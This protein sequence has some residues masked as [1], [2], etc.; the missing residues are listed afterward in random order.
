[1]SLHPT[2][3][4]TVVS[5]RDAKRRGLKRT[6]RCS[7][8]DGSLKLSVVT[9]SVIPVSSSWSGSR[10]RRQ[11]PSRL[12]WLDRPVRCSILRGPSGHSCH[13]SHIRIPICASARREAALFR[14]TS[15][16]TWS[17]PRTHPWWATP[18]KSASRGLPCDLVGRVSSRARS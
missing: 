2:I 15:G 14:R 3:S 4:M 12:E 18:R 9:P 17:S 16:E 1:M 7:C 8:W 11:M 13:T 10:D 6:C 5:D